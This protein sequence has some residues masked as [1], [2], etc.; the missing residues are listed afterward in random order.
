MD[1][2]TQ[3]LMEVMKINEGM[4]ERRLKR[5]VE[6]NGGKALKFISPSMVGLPD[7]IIL[8]PGGK[9]IFV[10]MKAH[11]KK[12]RPLQQKRKSQL[13]ALGFSVYCIDS[14]PAIDA[15]IKEVF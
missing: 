4:L 2:W 15:F 10:E 3:K 12:L 11:G 14:I 5:E 7:R 9:V 8:I 1:T 13:E 6:K